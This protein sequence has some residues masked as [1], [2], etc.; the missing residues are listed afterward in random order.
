MALV[1]LPRVSVVLVNFR[2]IE[3]T[4]VAIEAL[5]TVR[6]PAD[7]LEIVVVDNA[8]GDDSAARLRLIVPEIVLVESSQNLGFAGG[9]N[10]G[11][12]HSSGDIV[13][14]LNSDACPDAD[15]IAAAVSG[16]S[17]PAVGGVASRVLDWNGELVDFIDAGLT[18]FGKGYKPF[19]GERAG[20]RRPGCPARS[21]IASR[22]RSAGSP[23]STPWPTPTRSPTPPA[24]SSRSGGWVARPAG[25]TSPLSAP[26]RSG[27]G[28]S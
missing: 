7:R 15:W 6:W 19:V 23:P 14:F 26:S 13:A 21:D 25:A 5:H 18:W 8:S 27:S 3:D 1:P 22:R 11:V 10:L 28:A 2:G 4:L 12:K 17:D 24:S 16:F 20:T 9:C